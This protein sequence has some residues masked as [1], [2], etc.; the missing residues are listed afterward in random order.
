MT[1]YLD[2]VMGLNFVVDLL[3]LTGANRLAG[4]PAGLGRAVLG[5]A[6]GGIYGAVCLLPGF[7]FLGN[8]LWRTV[9]LGLMSLLAFGMG[10]GT[11]RR[12]VLFSFLS[13][14]LGGIVLA[15]GHP[16][17]PSLVAAAAGVWILCALGWGNG[18]GERRFV[19]VHLG[20]SGKT[21]DLTA[22][23]DTGNT[24]RDPVTGEQVLVAGPD[25]AK[26]LLGLDSDALRDPAGTLVR[27]PIPGLRLIPYRAIGTSQGMLLGIRIPEATINGQPSTVLTAFAPE[28]LGQG[29]FNALIGGRV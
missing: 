27:M 18:V 28:G 6:L 23:H 24:L 25:V 19:S 10:P 5:A 22:L 21:V 20:Y 3:L 26:M 8:M 7:R 17:V 16:G 15:L 12:G 29:E 14:A 2:L 9:S 4:Y 1:V 11:L 13:M